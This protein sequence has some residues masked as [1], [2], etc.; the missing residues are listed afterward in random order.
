MSSRLGQLEV[1][2]NSGLIGFATALLAPGAVVTNGVLTLPRDDSDFVYYASKQGAA[3][4]GTTDDHDALQALLDRAS[5]GSS[6]VWVIVDGPALTSPLRIYSN[7][8]LQVLAGCTIKLKDGSDRALLRNGNPTTST[9]TDHDITVIGGTWDGNSVNQ[10]GTGLFST[11]ESDG[12]LIGL[13]QFY[14]VKNLNVFNVNLVHSKTIALHLANIEHFRF[15]NIDIDNHVSGQYQQGGIQIEGPARYFSISN[16]RGTT[17]DDLLAFSTDGCAWVNTPFTGLGPLVSCGDITDGTVVN[18]TGWNVYSFVRAFNST[19][20]LDRITVSNLAGTF[21]MH[22][23]N[24]DPGALLPGNIGTLEFNNV[25]VSP[26]TA[27]FSGAAAININQRVRRLLFNNFSVTDLID[28]RPI[29][30]VAAGA[31]VDQISLNHLMVSDVLSAAAGAIPVT[32]AGRVR[33]ITGED[34]KWNRDPF[35][36]HAADFLKVSGGGS[37]LEEISINGFHTN[38]VNRLIYETGGRL[39]TVGVNNVRQRDTLGGTTVKNTG[40]TTDVCA[41]NWYAEGAIPFVGT[42]PKRR[43]DAFYSDGT[44]PTFS[45]AQGFGGLALVVVTFSEPINAESFTAGVT[46]KKGGVSQTILSTKRRDYDPT[47]VEFIIGGPVLV[48]DTVTWEY[49]AASGTYADLTAT[50]MANVSA[51]TVSLSRTG[52][53]HDTFENADGTAANGHTPWPVTAGNNWVTRI[54]AAAQQTIQG[55]RLR[56]DAQATSQAI[57]VDAGA[58]NVII[59][60]SM[61][62]TSLAS[63]TGFG[64]RFRVVDASNYWLYWLEPTSTTLFKIVAGSASVVGSALSATHFIDIVY[65]VQIILNGNSISCLVNGSENIST[66][67]SFNATATKAGAHAAGALVGMD[68]FLIISYA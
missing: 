32:I 23:L 58:A 28:T 42:T 26:V 45:A 12:T 25:A 41:S 31:E 18:V 21:M 39:G 66:T 15:D 47:T 63:G 1:R 2:N 6:R 38:R 60:T 22:A 24:F 55:H 40:A 13:F 46:I 62:I 48:T 4:N 64:V 52:Y 65:N 16:I 29:L 44:A 3:L 33:R 59:S 11:Q 61:F 8:T 27:P 20:L 50:A 68:D 57:D 34:W 9:P 7:T 51:Q 36:I 35:L 14:G 54:G 67:D 43:G 19:H 49:A 37:Q 30:N 10:T 56:L 17:E 53:V 5:S